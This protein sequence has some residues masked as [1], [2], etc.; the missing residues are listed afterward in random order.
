[1]RAA[2]DVVRTAALRRNADGLR[3]AGEH[4]DPVG[5]DHGVQH[6]GAAGL[7]LAIA[8]MAAMHEHGRG[9][10]PIP[11]RTAGAP[12]FQSITHII[13]PRDNAGGLEVSHPS[14]AAGSR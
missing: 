12:A 10:E 5:L 3:I 2:M 1:M 11:Y 7:A 14:A 6:E 9:A 13:P 4:R 8:T